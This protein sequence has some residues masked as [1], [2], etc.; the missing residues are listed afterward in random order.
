MTIPQTILSDSDERRIPFEVELSLAVE[1]NFE[2]ETVITTVEF[3][4]QFTVELDYEYSHRRFRHPAFVWTNEL[5][6]DVDHEF[7]V[8]FGP[9]TAPSNFEATNIGGGQIELTW[10]NAGVTLDL[11]LR[12]RVTSST[13]NQDWQLIAILAG[14]STSY[15]YQAPVFFD[16]LIEF[17]LNY[18]G[19]SA[20]AETEISI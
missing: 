4:N 10:A 14:G 9:S 13:L 17:R 8:T 20:F 7:E 15:L 11:E 6:L 5:E 3:S 1:H 19:L 12:S 18:V 2:V 16:A